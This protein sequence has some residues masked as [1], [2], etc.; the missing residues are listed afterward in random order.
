MPSISQIQKDAAVERETW[1]HP[2]YKLSDLKL[3]SSV[4]SIDGSQI[5]WLKPLP[6]DASGE[7]ILRELETKGVAHVKGVMP[8]E[9]VLD[10]R[11]K[12]FE[13]VAPSGVLK[14]GTDPVDGIYCGK[15]DTTEFLGPEGAAF[16]K[17]P[18]EENAHFMLATE[19]HSAPWAREFAENQ[20]LV[21]AAKRIHP[22]WKDPFCMRRQIF[23]S[24]LPFAKGTATGVH[25]DHIFLRGGPPTFLTAWVPIGDCNPNQGGLMYLEDTLEMAAQGFLSR[26]A[27]GYARE[28]GGG[29]R[30][31]IGDYEAGD[32]VFHHSFMIHASGRNVDPEGRIRLSAD[33]R[34][35]DRAAAY[36]RRWDK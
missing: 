27:V 19:A 6:A 26:D 12:W 7:E 35:A 10:M 21:N 2:N 32:A 29:R 23:R 4:G 9:Y 28:V 25:Y 34:F 36:D 30:W 18:R 22:Q 13:Q 11:R 5:A 17:G 16:I 3:E 8:R 31:L 1:Q 33:L 14:E 24:N 15:E 20:Y